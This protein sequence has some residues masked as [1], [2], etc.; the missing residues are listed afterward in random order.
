MQPTQ[1]LVDAAEAIDTSTQVDERQC[2]QEVHRL[3]N[4]LG[5]A[6]LEACALRRSA[7]DH[8]TKLSAEKIVANLKDASEFISLLSERLAAQDPVSHGLSQCSDG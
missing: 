6:M 5:I 3:R 8:D 4:V 1:A 2:V 7:Q